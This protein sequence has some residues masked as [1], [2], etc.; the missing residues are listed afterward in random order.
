MKPGSK[1][2]LVVDC[3]ILQTRAFDRGM[4]RYTASV[5][6]ELGKKS[7]WIVEILLNNNLDTSRERIAY[8]RSLI[9]SADVCRLDLPTNLGE[10]HKGKTREAKEI[11]TEKYEGRSITFLIT[12][13]FFVDFAS[14][15][16]S[17][18]TVVRCSIVYDFI[19][20]RLWQK[21]KIFPDDLYFYHFKSLIESDHLFT[22]SQ[23]VKDDMVE[24][25]G[26]NASSVTNIDG[27]AFVQ[28]NGATRAGTKNSVSDKFFLYPSAP[29]FHKNNE[30]AVRGFSAFNRRHNGAYKLVFTSSFDEDTQGRLRSISSDII[31]TGSVPEDELARLYTDAEAILFASYAEGLGMP[32]LEAVAYGKKVVCSN[33]AVLKEISGTAFTY[34]EPSSPRSIAHGLEESLVAEIDQNDYDR[35]LDK[36]RWSNTAERLYRGLVAVS[37]N[38]PFAVD[39]ED[40]ERLLCIVDDPTNGTVYGRMFEFVFAELSRAYDVDVIQISDARRAVD[41]RRPKKL[42]SYS[43][44]ITDNVVDRGDFTAYSAVLL[45]GRKARGVRKRGDVDIVQTLKKRRIKM[46]F[47]WIDRNL[48]M[49]DWVFYQ[50]SNR[51]S[52]TEMVGYIKDVIQEDYDSKK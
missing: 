36:Y 7:G 5:V 47:Q 28:N 13:P 26:F 25:F 19:P 30:N 10:D 22:I 21:Q 12:A 17:G 6:K 37:K 11:L 34:F 4:G 16:P 1:Q 32:I 27:G 20:Y 3:Q 44:Y 31:F 8:I 52:A 29:I 45:F 49:K 48:G 24:L 33:I 2:V 38:R 39:R 42:P 15:Y 40:Q 18:D 23:A 43:K 35:I 50:G 51:L 9:P 14:V 41:Y 46:N